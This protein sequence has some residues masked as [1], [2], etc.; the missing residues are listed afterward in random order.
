V[1]NEMRSVGDIVD[2][3]EGIGGSSYF[4]EGNEKRLVRDLTDC[5]EGRTRVSSFQVGTNEVIL[6]KI[7]RNSKVSSD[8]IGTLKEEEDQRYI[9]II[10]GISIFLPRS[11]VEEITCV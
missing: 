10:G 5:Q 6:S 4:H 11:P 1:G 3:Q 2:C 7:L 8:E 9:L